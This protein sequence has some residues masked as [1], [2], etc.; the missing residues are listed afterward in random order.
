MS[1][2][3]RLL[4]QIA[5][6]ADADGP[7]AQAHL[8]A[9]RDRFDLAVQLID[10]RRALHMTQQDLAA[11]SGLHQSVVSRIEQGVANP[12]AR[13]LSALARALGAQLT[14]TARRR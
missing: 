14:L 10:R 5:A 4:D 3:D 12:T 1:D 8:D 11:A 9:L 2:F 6:E 7:E 13:T